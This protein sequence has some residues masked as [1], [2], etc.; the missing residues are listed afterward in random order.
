MLML[1]KDLK[2]AAAIERRRRFEE[3]RKCRIFNARKRILGVD[4]DTL[5]RQ[6]EERKLKEEEEQRLNEAFEQQRIRDA[7]LATLLERKIEEDKRRM[8]SEINTFRT[9]YQKP[10][11]RREFDLYD[12]D[13]LKK[14]IPCRLADDDPR[15]GLSSAQKFEGEDL[16]SKERQK[17]QVEQ[18]RA[19]LE[20]QMAEQ[21]A[22]ENERKSAEEAYQAALVARDKRACDLDRMEQETRRRLNEATLRFNKAL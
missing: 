21:K 16:S 19:W 6:I 4:E 12:P 10:E 2:E 5:K 3:D 7:Q 13:R 11:N 1:P 18:Q 8:N 14:D 22:A 17:T 20:Q 9:V 15:C